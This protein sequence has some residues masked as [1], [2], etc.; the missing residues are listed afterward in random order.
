MQ[1]SK[2]PEGNC[3]YIMNIDITSTQFDIEG[4]YEEAKKIGLDA[5]DLAEYGFDFKSASCNGKT[6]FNQKNIKDYDDFVNKGSKLSKK[7]VA[8]GS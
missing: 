1:N 4:L 5:G 2:M 6:C 7:L 8:T 3:T